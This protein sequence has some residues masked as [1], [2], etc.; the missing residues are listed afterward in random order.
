[1]MKLNWKIYSIAGGILFL[2]IMLLFLEKVFFFLVIFLATVLVAAV[3]GFVQP[4]KYLGVEL[5]T[6]STMVIGVVYGPVVGGLYALVILPIHFI[7]GQYYIGTFLAWVVPEYILLGVLSGVLRSG[8]IG[9]LGVSFIIGLNLL[10]LFLTFLAES[11]RI[12][13]ELPFVVGN[14]A[15]NSIIFYQFFGSLVDFIS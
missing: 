6:L 7:L 2:A 15:I 4:L 5:V 14:I 13:K 9:T 12:G 3:L 10:N 8:I 1:M 11:D